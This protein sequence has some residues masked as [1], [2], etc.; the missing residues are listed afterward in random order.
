MTGSRKVVSRVI[1]SLLLVLWSPAVCMVLEES[2]TDTQL[3]SE[4]LDEI[5][6]YVPYTMFIRLL[7]H[8][9]GYGLSK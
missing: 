2:I 8:G 4:L 6:M 7:D 3:T 5:G 9:F 1:A